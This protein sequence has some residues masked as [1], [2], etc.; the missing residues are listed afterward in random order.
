MRLVKELIEQGDVKPKPQTIT[1]DTMTHA[2]DINA[3]ELCVLT[4]HHAS[5]DF[6]HSVKFS[7]FEGEEVCM[8]FCF[9]LILPSPHK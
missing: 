5:M 6:L 7:N 2:C 9:F 4:F 1:L 3:P 8:I